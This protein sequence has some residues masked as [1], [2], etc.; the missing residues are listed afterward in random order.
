LA[1]AKRHDPQAGDEAA[2][3]ERQV[4]DLADRLQARQAARVDAPALASSTPGAQQPVAL[5]TALVR[6]AVTAA[7][8]FHLRGALDQ[9]RDLE[10]LTQAVYYESRGESRN[11][12]QAVAQVILNRVRHPSF[13]KSICGVVF[14]GAKDG[15]CQFSFACDGPNK[16]R[17]TL[18]KVR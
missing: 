16:W 18:C 12:Q 7:Q 4:A 3:R 11:G 1:I 17:R 6:S 10:C 5:K 15:G 8:P 9:S 13:P 14:Q 2:S